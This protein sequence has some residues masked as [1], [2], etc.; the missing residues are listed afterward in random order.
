MCPVG[1]TSG[2]FDPRGGR[3]LKSDTSAESWHGVKQIVRVFVLRRS[4]VASRGESLGMVA[5][6]NSHHDR[7]RGQSQMR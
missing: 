6:R 1:C 2:R 4:G 3:A 7:E 5:E